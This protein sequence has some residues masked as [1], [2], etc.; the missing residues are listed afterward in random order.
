VQE[1]CRPDAGQSAAQ[2]CVVLAELAA[3]ALVELP[4]GLWEQPAEALYFAAVQAAECWRAQL[5]QQ[6]LAEPL[7]AQSSPAEL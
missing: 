1:L 5:A 2:S 6:V 3:A 7:V 4:P